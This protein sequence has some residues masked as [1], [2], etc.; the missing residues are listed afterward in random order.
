MNRIY[1]SNNYI[2][3]I[4]ASGL[5]FRYPRKHS[6][7][8]VDVTQFT[9]KN[10]LTNGKQII[11]NADVIAGNWGDDAAPIATP[12]DQGTMTVFLETNTAV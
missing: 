11:T 3:V 6:V 1:I 7:F 10:T 12:Y 2:I 4:L 9:L 8:T 5:Q